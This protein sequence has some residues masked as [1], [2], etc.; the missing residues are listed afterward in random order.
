MSAADESF[1]HL[2]YRLR[3]EAGRTQEEQAEAVNAVT[4]RETLTRREISR[5]ENNRNI[6]T[7][8]TVAQIAVACGVPP[9]QLQREATAARARRHSGDHRED[10]EQDGMRRR[11]LIEGAI[12]GA[13]AAAEPWGRLAHALGRG[14]RIDAEA[15][16]SL[17]QRAEALHI[18]ELHL[19]AHQ[20]RGHVAAHLD[21][22]TAALAHAG[23]HERALIVAAGE[24]AAL[25]GWLA[26]DLGDHLAARAYY[27]V[28]A[29]CAIAAGHPPLRALALTY[30]SYGTADP[31]QAIDLLIQAAHD[32][33]GPGAATAAAWVHAR[34]AEEAAR[35][36]EPGKTTSTLR[37]LDRAR[38]AYDYADH[39]TEHAWT[40]F[41]SPARLD[42]LVLSA[43]GRLSHPDLTDAAHTAAQ[44]LGSERS[45]AGV[46]ILGD[47]AA[48][49]LQGGD[50]DQGVYV[51]REFGAAATARPN[52]M[53][54]DRAQ[55]IIARLPAKEQDLAEHLRDLAS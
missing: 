40:R 38:T 44:Q 23:E 25:A 54:R 33:R 8:H 13:T 12:I 41:M 31:T 7:N 28:T 10:E 22:L 50:L 11:N 46:V 20:L 17:I 4:G 6:P 52:T 32:V 35:T 45:D 16:H 14:G 9:K 36:G 34:H 18:S 39:T 2:L 53:G 42:A 21:T 48:A 1:G 19:S 24:T 51:A 29:D 3:C 47:I 43:Y 26:W 15:A 5:Y 27:R 37:A 30:A 49:L 55:A